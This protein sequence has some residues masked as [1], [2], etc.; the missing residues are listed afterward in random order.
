MLEYVKQA[1]HKFQHKLTITPE[2]APH[3]HVAPT[4][5]W[6]VQ[7]EERVDKSNLMLTTETNIIQKVV[8][9]YLYYGLAIDN[10]VLVELND[11]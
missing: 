7:Y 3:A 5:C 1:L 6:H 10:T 8:R 2:Y 4:Y 9:K 11:I